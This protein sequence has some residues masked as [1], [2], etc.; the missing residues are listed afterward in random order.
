MSD[1]PTLGVAAEVQRLLMLPQ[2][3][4]KQRGCCCRAVT[5]K[6]SLSDEQRQTLAKESTQDGEHARVFGDLFK[7]YESHAAVPDELQ[8]FVERVRAL[9]EKKGKNPDDVAIYACR[10]VQD[11]GRCGV[12]EDRPMGCRA[13]PSAYK[14]T[15]FHPGCGFEAQAQENWQKIDT[16]IQDTFGISAEELMAPMLES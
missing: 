3:L 16:L 2:S 12:H 10:F 15:I 7:A 13:Y 6:G 5:F 14:D 8:G 9:A 1:E 11:D 4:C